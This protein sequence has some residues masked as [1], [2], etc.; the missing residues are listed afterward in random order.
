MK[1]FFPFRLDPVIKCLWRL[2]ETAEEE[3]ILL[4]PTAFALLQYLVDHAGQLVTQGQLLQAVWGDKH[5]QSQAVKHHIVEIR[6]ALGDDSKA[7][8]FIETLPRRGYR[9]IAPVRESGSGLDG[10]PLKPTLR[11]LVGRD[12][13]LR[14]LQ[15][16]L[17]N[18][19]HGER[20]II[21][22]T[23]EPGIGK[24]SVVDEFERLTAAE[25][26]I[27]ICR[28]QCVEGYGG[29]EPYYPMLEAVGKLSRRSNANFI[30][31]TL[32]TEAPTWL[33]QFPALVRPEQR[34][35][36]Q[37]EILGATRERML[38]EIGEALETITATTAV[39]LIFEDLQWV[40]HS[41]VDLISALARGREAAKLMLIGTYRSADVAFSDHPLKFVKQ[42]LLVHR[43]CHEIALEPLGDGQVAEYLASSSSEASVLDGLAALI[44]R[45]SEGNPL[46]MVAALDHMTER[47]LISCQNGVWQLNIPLAEID[48]EV[49]E[50]LRQMIEAQL[51]CLTKEER[52]ALEVASVA[53]GIFSCR[54]TA[55]AADMEQEKFADLC[56]GLSHRAL[57]VRPAG[58]QQ[59]PDG[60]VSDR[61]EF[62][63]ALY[64]EVFYGHLATGTKASLHER[65]GKQ[66][67]ALF[68][69]R[70]R[71]VAAELAYHFEQSRD[72]SRTVRYLRLLAE[73]VGRR[74]AHREA[75]QYLAARPRVGQQT[76]RGGTRQ[77]R[78]RNS[79]KVGRHLSCLFRHARHRNL[80]NLDRSS[81]LLRPPRR[82]IACP[83]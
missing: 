52:R 66:V 7:P 57:M 82:R 45:H 54:V 27:R 75:Q 70:P 3:R 5:V 44:H 67:E 15:S 37:R 31:E 79:G 19:L 1:E 47:G 38:R 73:N 28:G 74:Y 30:V 9:F 21:F 63:H 2:G 68:S 24:T 32:A 51:Q 56:E 48:L 18:A 64:R 76:T 58:S 53:G 40:D 13:V 46:F 41:T 60:T 81:R 39:V 42:D 50:N 83:D 55:S 78:D 6:T 35:M 69:E 49:P 34:E 8:R 36:L 59:F 26:P 65:I 43:L 20:Q 33:V 77:L 22:I 14:E 11:R 4:A 80:R 71:E 72:W 10:Q 16:Y 12:R 29:K 62:V 25:V 17:H 23:G 61:Y